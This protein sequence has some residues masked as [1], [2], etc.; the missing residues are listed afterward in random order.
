MTMVK[1]TGAKSAI[2]LRKATPQMR[3]SRTASRELFARP[4]ARCKGVSRSHASVNNA[5]TCM[6]LLRG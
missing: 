4:M 5:D 6:T 3:F 1:M 2:L